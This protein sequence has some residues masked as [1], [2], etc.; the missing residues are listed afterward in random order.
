MVLVTLFSWI[1]M[2]SAIQCK[3]LLVADFSAV[4]LKLLNAL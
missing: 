1:L 4:L 3:N 2:A